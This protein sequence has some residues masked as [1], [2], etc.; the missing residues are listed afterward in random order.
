MA[1]VAGLQAIAPV[2]TAAEFIDAVLNATMRKTPTG[3]H[4]EPCV[5][6]QKLTYSYS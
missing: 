1:S 3:E 6:L 5:L 2:P 4:I